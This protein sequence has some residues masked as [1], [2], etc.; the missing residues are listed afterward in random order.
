MAGIPAEQ[1]AAAVGALEGVWSEWLGR[2]GVNW[3]DVGPEFSDGSPTGRVAVRVFVDHKLPAFDVPSDEILPDALGEVPV[4]VLQAPLDEAVKRSEAELVDLPPVSSS[5]AVRGHLLS[6]VH[7]AEEAE[8]AYARAIDVEPDNAGAWEGL[9][10]SRIS[11]GQLEGAAEALARAADLRPDAADIWAVLGVVLIE[12]GRLDEAQYAYGRARELEPTGE[13]VRD[14]EQRLADAGTARPATPSRVDDVFT[15]SDAPDPVDRLGRKP[16]AESL[17]SRLRTMRTQDPATSFLLHIDGPWGAG[18]SS[19]LIYL[20][21]ELASDSL[22]V[23]VNAWREQRVGPPWLG[24]LMALRR[25]ALRRYGRVLRA[26]E[27]L[28]R[29]RAVGSVYLATIVVTGAITAA[30]LS[31]AAAGDFNVTSLGDAAVSIAAVLALGATVWTTTA[32]LSRRLLPGSPRQA[33]KYV[34]SHADPMQK[35]AEHFDEFLGLVKDPVVFVIDDLD[36]CGEDYVV[37]F[38]EAVQTLLQDAPATGALDR[39]GGTPGRPDQ[40]APYFV[41]AADGRWIRASYEHAYASFA[42]EVTYPGRPLGYLFLEK[43]FQ[44]T[45]TLPAIDFERRQEYLNF[46]LRVGE[47]QDPLRA[48]EVDVQR[49]E[50]VLRGT[51]TE[52]EILEEVQRHRDDTPSFRFA[53]LGQA[54]KQMAQPDVVERLEHALSPFADL[55]DPNPRAMKRFVNAFGV[56]R[57]LRTMEQRWPTLE[58]LARWTILLL[59]WPG[60]ATVLRTDPD[61]VALVGTPVRGA[62]PDD[63]R[64]LFTDPDVI[65][66]IKGSDPQHGA[67]LDA[68]AIRECAGLPA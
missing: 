62:A 57:S 14:L 67:P 13:Q 34:E 39:R 51:H 17:A 4:D 61:A 40:P 55:L 50:A 28:A 59:R 2:R 64:R 27:L 68:A 38:L 9:G 54:V 22:V 18:K 56:E 5:W 53:L 23:D 37:E 10:V 16:F 47:S 7:R 48:H 11:T 29:L 12:L 8:A 63:V 65:R 21:D 24:L 60:L 45:T 42:G 32:G 19:L 49:A 46:L 66:V 58:Q 15:L 6:A 36:R 30:L 35:V 44:L 43:A 52:G 25:A 20:R 33:E 3:L 26:R 31:W 41:V 1:V